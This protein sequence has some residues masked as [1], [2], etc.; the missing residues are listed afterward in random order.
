M[1]RK[2]LTAF[3]NKRSGY[4]TVNLLIHVV[5]VVPFVLQGTFVDRLWEKVENES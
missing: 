5:P 3:R 4:A 2:A 1:V